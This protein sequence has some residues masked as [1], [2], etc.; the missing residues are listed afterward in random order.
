[1]LSKSVYNTPENTR[2]KSNKKKD[3]MKEITNFQI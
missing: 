3:Q 2:N 1:M